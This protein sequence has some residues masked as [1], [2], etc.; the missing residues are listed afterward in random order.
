M[1]KVFNGKNIVC[2]GNNMS[3]LNKIEDASIDL[4]YIDPPFNT[5]KVMRLDSYKSTKNQGGLTQGFSGYSYD[6]RKISSNS[7]NDKFENFTDF[8]KPRLI[9]SYRVLKPN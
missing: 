4:I 2:F 8:L 5:G 3:L 1:K 6:L 9:E 7:Y